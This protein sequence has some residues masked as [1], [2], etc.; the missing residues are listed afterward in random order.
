MEV[1]HTV[2]FFFFLSLQDE[3]FGVISAEAVTFYIVLEGEN[4]EVGCSTSSASTRKF[5]CREECSLK[6]IIIETPRVS[7]QEGRF[8]IEWKQRPQTRSGDVSVKVSQ[9]T[10]SDSGRYR[11]GLGSSLSSASYTD[12]EIIVVDAR[13]EG[14]RREAVRATTGGS[15]TAACSFPASSIF[16]LRSAFFCKDECLFML[17]ESVDKTKQSDRYSIRYVQFP[18]GGSSVYVSISQLTPSD[19][20]RY[21]C[22]LIRNGVRDLERTFEVFVADVSTTPKHNL[23]PS[24]SVPSAATTPSKHVAVTPIPTEQSG[25]TT[26]TEMLLYAGLTLVNLVVLFSHVMII[27][28][29]RKSSKPKGSTTGGS[30]DYVNMEIPPLENHLPVSSFGDSTY[31]SLNPATRDQNQTYST[32]NLRENIHEAVKIQT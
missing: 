4:V 23:I 6:D 11:C 32:L 27:F 12:I 16:S 2:I 28:C 24:T 17:I 30:K 13:L 14:N 20:G 31:E 29:R 9:L 10:K 21:R 22:G 19:S 7:A 5:F 3:N 15:F 26:T 18:T 25:T 1:Y 8:S